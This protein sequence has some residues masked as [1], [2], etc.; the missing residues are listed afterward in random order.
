MTQATTK[1]LKIRQFGGG[2]VLG[3]HYIRHNVADRHKNVDAPTYM[4]TGLSGHR[5]VTD[6]VFIYHTV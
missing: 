1:I 2:G 5:K 3:Q 4:S 6:Y